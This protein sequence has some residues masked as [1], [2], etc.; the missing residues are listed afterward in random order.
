MNGGVVTKEVPLSG[1]TAGIVA[2]FA[3][4]RLVFTMGSSDGRP[5]GIRTFATPLAGTAPSDV[6]AGSSSSAGGGG[7]LGDTGGFGDRRSKRGLAGTLGSFSPDASPRASS[8]HFGHGGSFAS[9]ASSPTS[10]EAAGGADTPVAYRDF[11]GC[12]TA[13]VRIALSHDDTRLFVAGLVSQV[14]PGRD[15]ACEDPFSDPPASLCRS[16]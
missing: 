12:S 2:S 13:G 6:A 8:R 7:G 1:P 15:T 9:P 3:L 5:S 4:P 14:R 16:P 11:P 10:A